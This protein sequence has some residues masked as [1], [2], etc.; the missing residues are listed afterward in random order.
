M[1]CV[2]YLGVWVS[3]AAVSSVFQAGRQVSLWYP[4]SGLSFGLLLGFGLRYTPVLLVTDVLAKVVGVTPDARWVDAVSRAGW[5][6]LVYAGCA[7]VLLRRVRIDPRLRTQRD[8][9]W[10]LALG[11]VL[12][13]L[14]AAAGQVVQYDLSGLLR[15]RDLVPN[16]AAFWSGSATG[17]GMLT[18]ALLVGARELPGLLVG[19]AAR[20]PGPSAGRSRRWEYAAQAV[21]L[22]ATV[23]VAYGGR[24]ERSLDFTYVVYVPLIWIAVRGGFPGTVL[25][26]FATNI[27][28]VALVGPAAA[29]HPLRLQLGL[30]TLTL[31]ALMLG[32]L[33]SQ[34]QADAAAAAAAARRDPLTGLSTRAVLLER[35]TAVIEDHHGGG[36]SAAVFYG[37]LDS[38]KSINDG[39]GH[40]A[41]DRLLRAVAHRVQTSIRPGD[42]AARLGGDEF[43]VVLAP[44]GGVAEAEDVADRLVGALARPYTDG[45]REINITA[46]VGIAVIDPAATAPAPGVT[47]VPADDPGLPVEPGSS[48]APVDPAAGGRSVDRAEQLLR[49]ADAALQQAKQH[50]G[51][52]RELFDGALRERARQRVRQQAALRR[53]VAENTLQVVYQPIVSLPER[54]TVTVEALTR[55]SDLPGSPVP[56]ADFIA[57]AEDTGLIHQLGLQVLDRACGDLTC[58]RATSA[59]GLRVAVNVSPRQLLADDF[60]D[61]VLRVLARHSLPVDAV[62]LEIT[63]SSAM[64]RAGPTRDV[65]RRLTAAGLTLIIDDFGT[66]YSSFSVLH[67]LPFTGLKIDRSFISRLPDDPDTAGIV[68]AIVSMATHLRLQVT[69]EGVETPEQLA[70]VT[71]LGCDHG[72]GFLLGR[73]LPPPPADRRPTGTPGQASTPDG[74]EQPTHTS[75]C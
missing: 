5:T 57:L 59:P 34:R 20:R 51:N 28:A 45:D 44:I 62:E 49:G 18:P 15:W 31:A 40:D 52:R 21:V 75:R 50:G 24:V 55:W 32:A 11:C 39:L 26:V 61:E 22:L 13:P 27:V 14:V 66:G 37:D 63:E 53:A 54:R 23:V 19:R 38:F 56:P 30:V 25:A 60:P 10:F 1:V 71:A 68:E 69:A 73:P 6:T 4:P 2:V 48:Q 72:Q 70:T 29:E 12:G 8:V 3:L 65:L 33:V 7:A 41:G 43:A 64:D 46:S 35:L 17:I 9:G 36:S 58:W 67:D 42:L 16:A 47:A 74:A